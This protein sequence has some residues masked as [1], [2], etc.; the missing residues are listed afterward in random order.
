MALLMIFWDGVGLGKEDPAEN[1][2]FAASLPHFR[3][4]FDGALPSLQNRRIHSAI[5]ST[6]PVNTTLGVE[7]LPQ[8][9]TGQTA[10]FTGINAPRKIGK[11][12]GP[13]PYS[14]LV[15]LVKERN[16]FVQLRARQKT[17]FFANAFPQRYFD[18]LNSPRSKTPTVAL[19]YLAA[20]GKLNTMPDLEAGGALSADITNAGLKSFS[21]ELE[22]LSPYDAG[23]RFH[24]LG[25]ASDFTLFEYFFSDKAGHA[26][27][28]EKAVEVLECMDGFLGGIL[29]SFEMERDL[30]LFV[31]DHGNIEDLT[32]KSHTRNPVPLIV[33]GARRNFFIK[34]V[35]S[36]TDVTPALLEFISK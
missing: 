28:M 9:G 26:Q 33:V 30:L 29:Q 23:R 11:H 10:L 2:F 5:A 27:S 35:R 12:F 20:G 13:H 34:R 16:I 6:V 25:Q 7:G 21:E 3:G 22:T 4:L 24:R 1:P 32:T 15:P 8:S 14:T 17:I 31:S 36:L 19:A 18:Y